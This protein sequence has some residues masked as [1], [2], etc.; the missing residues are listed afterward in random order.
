MKI[1][2]QRK[3]LVPPELVSTFHS[4]QKLAWDDQASISRIGDTRFSL[5]AV[6]TLHFC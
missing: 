2:G 5:M 4:G 1:N 3:L 6:V